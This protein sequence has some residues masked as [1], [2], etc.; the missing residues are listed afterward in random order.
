MKV[1]VQSASRL[2]R[3]SHFG[4]MHVLAARPADARATMPRVHARMRDRNYYLTQ[5]FD[6]ELKIMICGH[7]PRD[8]GN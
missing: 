8:Y 7:R 6:D 2:L 3:E 5:A 1:I 4:G